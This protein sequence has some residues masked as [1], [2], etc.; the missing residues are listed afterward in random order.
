M[1]PISA[2][3]GVLFGAVWLAALI[4]VLPYLKDA[5]LEFAARGFEGGVLRIFL[6]GSV[7][8]ISAYWLFVGVL[9]TVED[10]TGKDFEVKLKPRGWRR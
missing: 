7:A 9:W 2:T 4:W 10:F 6:C 1:K 8:G 3:I 5:L